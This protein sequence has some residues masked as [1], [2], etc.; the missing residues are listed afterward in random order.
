VKRHHLALLLVASA[1]DYVDRVE[2]P[3]LGEL[4]AIDQMI[5]VEEELIEAEWASLELLL[6][7]VRGA[8]PHDH[9]RDP[10]DLD[11]GERFAIAQAMVRTGWCR[12]A[13]VP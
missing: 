13:P 2:E 7:R 11:D 4:M 6:S 9:L 5:E 1:G 12:A 8:P 3:S 10:A